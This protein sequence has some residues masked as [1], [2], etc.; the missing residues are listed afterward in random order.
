MQHFLDA[1]RM[2]NFVLTK[3]EI[4][5]LSVLPILPWKRIRDLTTNLPKNNL[6]T[7]QNNGVK[8][9]L[10]NEGCSSSGRVFHTQQ[11]EPNRKS[12]TSNSKGML[13][14]ATWNIRTLFQKGKLAN[15]KQE[16]N[17]LRIDIF[18]AE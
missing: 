14:I 2:T 16:M 18:R 12:A 11:V 17:H 5:N 4:Q 13:Q 6:I 9:V 10:F 3:A 1:W 15:V 8:E 7:N